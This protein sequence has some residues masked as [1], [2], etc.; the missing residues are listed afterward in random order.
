M[1]LILVALAVAIAGTAPA[2]QPPGKGKPKPPPVATTNYL[3]AG[4]GG[5]RLT[6]INGVLLLAK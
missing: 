6:T 2:A 5:G 3:L 1:R 4:P